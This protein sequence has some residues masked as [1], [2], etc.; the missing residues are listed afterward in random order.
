MSGPW[1]L[2]ATGLGAAYRAGEADPVEAVREG[3]ER[4][5]RLD[6]RLNCFVAMNQGAEEEAAASAE[7]L[8]EGRPRGP[9]DGVPLAIKDNLVAAGM[10]ASWGSRLFAGVACEHDELPIARLREAGA[11][12]LGKTN[13]P[14]FAVEGYTANALHGVTGNAWDPALTP[15]GSSGGSASAVAAGLAPAAM[16]TDGGGSIR[17]PAAYA[18]LYGLKPSIGRYP[19]AGGLPRLLLDF[20]VVGPLARS[21]RDLRLLHAVLAGADRADPRSRVVPMQDARAEGLRILYVERLG[22][23]PL[24]PGIRASVGAAVERLAAMGHRV[25]AGTMPFDT[26]ELDAGWPRIGQVGLAAL[27]AAHPEMARLAQPRYLAMADA[28]CALAAPEL[29]RLLEIVRRLRAEASLFFGEWDAIVTPSCAAQP[30]EADRTH[31]E[32]IDD[33]PVG[34]R[35]HAVYTGWVNACGHPA[36]NMPAEPD[37]N[38]MPVGFQVVADLGAEERLIA[39]AEAWDAA[40]GGWTAW[41][42]IAEARGTDTRGTPPHLANG[43]SEARRP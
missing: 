25:E 43:R 23:A 19:R 40:T 10:P 41:P 14:E 26:A 39:L 8:R 30:W 24:D 42:E 22:D 35:G 16:G 3:R 11:I 1:R 6:P 36:L 4:I 34:P 21:G 31:P 17:R 38:G 9:L 13:T 27:R 7:R 12:V 29:W 20:E 18:G 37:A 5:A 32:A 15:G 33:R 28:G 2:D